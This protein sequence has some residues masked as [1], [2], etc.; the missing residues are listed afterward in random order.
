M[1]IGAEDVRTAGSFSCE[2]L[3]SAGGMDW[4]VPAGLLDWDCRATAAHIADALGFY[5]AHLASRA[6]QWLKFD[7]VPHVDASHGHLARLVAAMAELLAR[8]V[9]TTPEDV[10]AFHHSGMWD[11]GT[12]AAFGCLEAIVHTGDIAAGLT[13]H[14]DP[15]RDV[16]RRIAEHVFPGA[17]READPWTVLWWATG[18]GELE[19]YPRHG[20]DWLSYWM[21][22]AS[23]SDASG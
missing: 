20:P 1:R 6:D 17:P 8:V 3:E 19:G 12:L 7:V 22:A 18:R 4:S 21:R 11:R 14:Y 15:P 9:E 23:A 5:A 13:L 16:C 10:R 2:F